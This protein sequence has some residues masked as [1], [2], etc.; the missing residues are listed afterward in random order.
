M[1]LILSIQFL[2]LATQMRILRKNMHNIL[3]KK[4]KILAKKFLKIGTIL[5]PILQKLLKKYIIQKIKNDV[6]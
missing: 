2:I 5:Y 6:C 1:L 3:M 4:L